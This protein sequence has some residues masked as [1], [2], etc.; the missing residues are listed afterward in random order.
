MGLFSE[1]KHSVFKWKMGVEAIGNADRVRNSSAR[2]C[3][4]LDFAFY[5]L[6]VLGQIT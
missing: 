5:Q 2:L 4:D 1:T 3:F 6:Y